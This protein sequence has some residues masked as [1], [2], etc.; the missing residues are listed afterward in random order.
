MNYL[1]KHPLLLLYL[2]GLERLLPQSPTAPLQ[3][4][5]SILL[6]NL[7]HLGDLVS[8]TALLP[9]LKRLYPEAKIGFLIGSWSEAV[10]KDHPLIDRLH[11][12]DHWR[13]DRSSKPLPEKMI[14]Y[15]KS[16]RR[17]IR[18]IQEERYD[19]GVDLYPYFPNSAPLLWRANIP[20]RI[21]YSSGGFGPLFTHP[22]PWEKKQQ[23]IARYQCALFGI[24]EEI[25][26][27]L[28]AE[29]IPL[30]KN[31]AVLHMGTGARSKEWS[32]S[33]WKRVVE[34]FAQKN[35]PLLFTGRGNKEKACIERM[36]HEVGHGE[37]YCNRLN[38]KQFVFL[39][40]HAR[41]IVSVDTA[42]GHIA[43]SSKT[44]HLMI[45]PDN[46]CLWK[47]DNPRCKR[48]STK[49]SLDTILNHIRKEIEDDPI[50]CE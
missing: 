47:P 23:S 16:G 17:A 24:E 37:N 18:Q 33:G 14:T 49:E 29:R 7:A 11:F 22:H 21:G 1:V 8:A 45:S 28:T 44:A 50:A 25:S 36:I 12:V 13:L 32:H 4:P 42:I 20:V 41:F 9:P 40:Q 34:Y 48:M 19:W 35:Y 3:R 46:D 38:W 26:P 30:P 6:S 43:A 2:R 39:V 10:L 15:M 31:Y 27:C 5:K